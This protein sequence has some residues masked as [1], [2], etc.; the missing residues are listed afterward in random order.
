MAK[1][2]RIGK[3]SKP[4]PFKKNATWQIKDS[5]IDMS[6]ILKA[7]R[8][9]QKLEFHIAVVQ[10]EHFYNSEEQNKGGMILYDGK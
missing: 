1:V 9:L 10:V 7:F 2:F 3:V 6:Y 8:V 4:M 5:F